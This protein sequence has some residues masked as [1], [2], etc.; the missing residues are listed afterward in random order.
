MHPYRE[1]GGPMSMPDG[2]TDFTLQTATPRDNGGNNGTISGLDTDGDTLGDCVDP[3]ADNDGWLNTCETNSSPPRNPLDA[4][5]MPVPPGGLITNPPGVVTGSDA[6]ADHAIDGCESSTANPG[7]TTDPGD[8]DSDGDGV[9][10]GV[11]EG[12]GTDP[13]ANPSDYSDGA[14]D[15]DG[16]GCTNA[17]ELAADD[18]NPTADRHP[19]NFWDFYS[20]DDDD[21]GDYNPNNNNDLSDTVDLLGHFG[22]GY[23]GG[24]YLTPEGQGYDR[25][26]LLSPGP[27]GV[28]IEANNGIDLSEALASLAQFGFGGMG[29]LAPGPVP[30]EGG[31]IVS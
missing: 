23:N 24:A 7:G 22:E 18:T 9:Q 11:E 1:D 2:I 21:I 17:K 10:D 14:G 28:L 13:N 26:R 31:G 25:T 5:S 3:D 15:D 12:T 29:C 4:G 8:A 6:D 16:D 19:G 27:P 20:V 30:A